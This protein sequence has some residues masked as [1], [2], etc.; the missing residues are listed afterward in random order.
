[1]QIADIAGGALMA[2]VGILSAVIARMQTGTGQFVDVSMLDGSLSCN[3]YHILMYQLTGQLPQRG[4]EQ[5]TGRYPCY[6]VYETRDGRHVT[7][8]A[9]E[10]HFWTTLCRHF[11]R[12]DFIPRQW[13]A[14]ACEEMFAFFRAAFRQKTMVEWVAELADQDICFGPVNTLDETFADP[15]LRQRSM[16]VEMKGPQGTS[17][18]LGTPIKLSDTPATLRTP[19]PGFGEHTDSVLGGLGFS[20]AEIAYLRAAGVV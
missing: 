16:L 10:P 9:F 20:T 1:V 19:P 13:D 7:V 8:G 3:A 6:A 17:T 11:D 12:E 18:V 2:T 15:Q 5:L 4:G 14:D